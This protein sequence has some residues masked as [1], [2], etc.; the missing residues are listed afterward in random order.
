MEPAHE[1][2]RKSH[3]SQNQH[4][5]D[6]REL[7]ERAPQRSGVGCLHQRPSQA[8]ARIAIAVAELARVW[9]R[10]DNPEFWRI[11]LRE[12]C[13]RESCEERSPMPRLLGVDIPNDKPIVIALRY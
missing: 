3:E 7:Q 9:T 10:R 4:Q 8:A 1:F 2:G 11:R 6:L 13:A 5:A 12:N